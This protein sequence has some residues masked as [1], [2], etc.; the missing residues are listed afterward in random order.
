MIEKEEYNQ[1]QVPKISWKFLNYSRSRSLFLCVCRQLR[2]T[3]ATEFFVF[4]NQRLRQAQL[5]HRE[6]RGRGIKQK[7]EWSKQIHLLF[8]TLGFLWLQLLTPHVCFGTS[9]HTYFGEEKIKGRGKK[10]RKEP[11]AESRG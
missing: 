10:D 7:M 4:L 11:E 2:W 6:R 3:S 9:P 1:K 5:V 8:L